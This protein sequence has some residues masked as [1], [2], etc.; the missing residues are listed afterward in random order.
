MKYLV[1]WSGGADSTAMLNYYAGISSEDYPIRAITI[2]DH[3]YIDKRQMECQ[4]RAQ[5]RYLKFSKE[6][7]YWINQEVMTIGGDFW[8]NTPESGNPQQ[9]IMWLSAA[10]QV[11]NDKETVLFSYIKQDCLWHFKREFED[12]FK[13]LCDLRGVD[14]KLE[15]PFEWKTKGEVLELLE[16][17]GVPESCWWSCEHPRVDYS[18][19]GVC[20]KCKEVRN[21][22]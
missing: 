17:D 14:A 20:E 15:F 10:C 13:G 16:K 19:C 6:K 21:I 4:R 3:R 2:S 18:R 8:M 22:R 12:A 11:V 9:P 1:V 5:D 7:G